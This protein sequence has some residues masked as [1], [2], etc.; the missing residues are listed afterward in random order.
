MNDALIELLKEKE[1]VNISIIEICR[2][3]GVNRSTFYAHYDNTHDLLEEVHC[4]F[5]KEMNRYFKSINEVDYSKFQDL[6]IAP[7]Y[8]V[9]YL[10]FIKDNKTFFK[11]YMTNLHNYKRD[12]FYSEVT[13]NIIIPVCKKN[14]V[15]DQKTIDYLS[16]FYLHGI[17][18]V[19]TH[20]VSN[21]CREDIQ[22]ICD[23]I[24]LCVKP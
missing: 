13:D 23:M 5:S 10:E 18:A 8:L 17:N 22:F 20:W 6:L 15:S 4:N 9:P 3:A 2:K 7:E 21:D 24:M 11:T 16:K 12:E 1:F 14:G 19:I